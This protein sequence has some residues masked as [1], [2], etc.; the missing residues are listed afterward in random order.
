M[1]QETFAFMT[2]SAGRPSPA[3]R[4]FMDMVVAHMTSPELGRERLAGLPASAFE[5]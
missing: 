4:A 1:V 5:T 3:T 2:R